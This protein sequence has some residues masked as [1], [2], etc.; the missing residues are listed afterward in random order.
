[1]GIFEE[2]YKKLN[3]AQ[4]EAV[5]SI[6]GPVM[7]VA[8]P[9]TGKTQVLSLRI[10]NILS[11]TDVKADDVLCLTFTNSGVRSMRDRLRKYIGGESSKVKIS[12][13][14]GFGLEILEKFYPILGLEDYPKLLNEHDL[15]SLYDDILENN[16][17]KY[18]RPRNDSARYYRD[19]RGLISL[20]K[21]E[22]ITPSSIEINIKKE[23]ESLRNDPA[24]LSSRGET[25]G[26][27]KKEIEKRIEG[28]NRT[29]EAVHFYERYEDQKKEKGWFDFDDILSSLLLLVEQSEEV[30]NYIKENYLYVLID[31]H[32]DSSGIQNEFLVSVWGEEEKPNIFVVG[33]DRQLIYG[34][35]GASL[36]YFENFKEAFGKAKLITLTE[37][38][39]S[40][41]NILASAHALLQSSI[42]EEVLHS[43]TKDNENVR[44]METYFNRDEIILAGLEIKEKIKKGEDVNEIAILVPKNR[45]VRTTITILK[46]MGIPVAGLS[47]VDFFDTEEALSFLRILK[48]VANPGDGV[49][50]SESFFDKSSQIPPLEA[51]KFILNQNMRSFSLLN[52][53]IENN[54]LFGGQ[55]R[56]NSWIKQLRLWVDDSNLPLYNLIQKIGTEFLINKAK[57]HND[58]LLRVEVVRTVLHLVL[59]QEEKD[60]EINLSKFLDFIARVV[61]YGE[62]IPLALFGRDDGVKVMTLHASKGL[63]FNYVWIA[64]MDEKSFTG[65]KRD[66]FTLPSQVKELV[67]KRDELVKKRELYVAITR[68]KK[69]C[70]ISYAINSYNGGEQEIAHVLS[71]I[72]DLFERHSAKE[73][74][75]FILSLDTQAFVGNKQKEEKG[76]DS[77]TSLV[78]MVA[79]NYEDRKVSVSLLNNFFECPWKWYFRNLLQLP[80]PKSESLE[81]G[82][83]VHNSINKI[84]LLNKIPNKKELEDITEGHQDVLNVVSNWVTNRLSKISKHRET[85]Q[86]ISILDDRF[87]HLNIYGKIDLIENLEPGI[88]RVVD[89]KT[90]TVRKNSEIEKLDDEGRLSSYLRQ[91][92]MYSYLI[93]GNL[94]WKKEVGESVLEFVEAK[95]S[96]ESFYRTR[97]TEDQL[98]LIIKDIKDYDSMLRSGDWV[99]RPCHYNSYGK[100]T[101][102][103]YCKMSEIYKN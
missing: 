43:N 22:S 78:E 12:T 21:R 61:T 49:S 9:G 5:D 36:K 100:N 90:G 82:N 75:D 20:L 47:S 2:E 29:E 40:T 88:V 93:T 73:N 54:N 6:D 30:K 58:L 32:Q 96:E 57:S 23:V 33:D 26:K 37:N 53:N 17:W 34:F 83:M 95:N 39:R 71:D 10:G 102:C 103:G 19:L 79:K 15:I 66:G 72:Q 70:T 52:L 24:N 44:I 98:N 101:S 62:M 87:P 13:F 42:S 59:L 35:G 14:H 28:L 8:G 76:V 63:E 97:I 91:L 48:I 1:M 56:V 77:L 69:F 38:Y 84:I 27:I 45:Q 81:F 86:S 89:F 55:D 50:V 68:A 3:K 92:A 31:E 18:L 46:E 60:P 65:T 99:N 85:E 25:K 80:E 4:K 7:V 16:E 51:H 64:H 74:E 67:E 41:P 94:K 11:K